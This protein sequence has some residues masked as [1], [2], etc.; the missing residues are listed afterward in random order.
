MSIPLTGVDISANYN[1]LLQINSGLSGSGGKVAD[2]LGN[3]SALTLSAGGCVVAGTETVQQVVA[4]TP[5]R[6]VRAALSPTALLDAFYS[7][8][9]TA[10]LFVD[11]TFQFGFDSTGGPIYFGAY[12]NPALGEAGFSIP[13]AKIFNVNTSLNAGFFGTAFP[14]AYG[15]G[16]GVLYLGNRTTLPTSAPVGGGFLVSDNGS[17]CWYGPSGTVTVIAPP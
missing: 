10:L 13:G 16:V 1:Q 8:T 5:C 6:E 9:G 11:H 15:G 7:S 3:D 17:L 12:G 2:G 4:G 14:T